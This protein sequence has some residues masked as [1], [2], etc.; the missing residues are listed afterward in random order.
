MRRI[1]VPRSKAAMTRAAAIMTRLRCLVN[2][3]GRA[4]CLHSLARVLAYRAGCF[5][6]AATVMCAPTVKGGVCTCS[7]HAN[8]LEAA[9]FL[10]HVC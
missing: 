4:R 7:S 10:T 9:K 3:Y 6:I 2:D 1:E 8:A 5:S